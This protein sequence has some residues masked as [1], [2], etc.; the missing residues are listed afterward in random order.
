MGERMTQ[1]WQGTNGFRLMPTD[2]LAVAPATAATA[3]EAKGAAW[4]LRY[5]WVHPQDGEQAGIVLFGTPADDA[6]VT[7]AWSDSWHQSPG[8]R[9]LDGT[10]DGHTTHLT[11]SYD[12]W[13]WTITV[14][15]TE[16]TLQVLMHNVIPEGLEGHTPGPYVVMD[17]TFSAVPET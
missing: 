17:G 5:T 14:T 8:L 13:G 1:Q 3:P 15:I 2:D 4:A 12:G 16:P 11:T 9:M 7:A 10:V 6:T